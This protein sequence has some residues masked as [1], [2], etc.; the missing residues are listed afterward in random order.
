MKAIQLKSPQD[1]KKCRDEFKDK[2]NACW[3]MH[4]WNYFESS[5]CYIP[6]GDC[7]ISLERAKQ[8]KFDIKQ[9]LIKSD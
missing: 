3:E 9:E 1:F 4:I 5:T 6:S 8:L 2:S 7:F